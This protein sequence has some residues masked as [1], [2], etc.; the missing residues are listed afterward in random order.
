MKVRTDYSGPLDTNIQYKDFSKAT[1][2]KLLMEAT[3]G[4]IMVD[5]FWHSKVAEKYGMEQAD[6]WGYEVWGEDWPRHMMPRVM[7]ALNIHG[8]DVEALL[9]Y[10]Q[11]DPGLPK[12]IFDYEVELKDKNHGVWTVN[13]CPSLLYMEKEGKG[14][15]A[16]VCP[17]MEYKAIVAYAKFFNPKIEVIPLKVPPRKCRDEVPHC[18]WEYRLEV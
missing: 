7:A 2:I 16:I 9:K 13:R 5:G 11:L 8:D 17:G 1:L 6:A 15:E 12:G 3:R 14:R 18:Q 10:I 4:L